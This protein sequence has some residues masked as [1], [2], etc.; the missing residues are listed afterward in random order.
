[1]KKALAILLTLTLVLLLVACAVEQPA[2][3]PD[4][5]AQVASPEPEPAQSTPEPSPDAPTAPEAPQEKIIIDQLG[6]EVVIPDTITSVATSHGPTTAMVVA[7]GGGDLIVG[8]GPKGSGRNIFNDV[9]PLAMS[10]PQIGQQANLNLEE[11]ARINPDLFIFPVRN[12][13]ILDDLETL[14]ILG[15]AIDPERFDSII[16]A[17]RIV[18][19]AI[20]NDEH[21]EEVISLVERNL[22]TIGER[23]AGVANAPTAIIT[24]RGSMTEVCVSGMLQHEILEIAGAQNMAGEIE[25]HAAVDVGLEQLLVWNPDYIFIAAFG[26]MQPEDFYSDEQ[27]ADLSAVINRRVYKIPS[28][29]DSWETP[30]PA[31]VLATMWIT[32]IIHPDLFTVEEFEAGMDEFYTLLYGRTFSREDLGF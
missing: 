1:M 32:H 30:Q 18:G 29:A 14:E 31:A 3:P 19:A 9:A 4:A 8:T 7:M 17:M 21:A 24:G 15:V 10:S 13:E 16:A 28:E 20:N 25:G 22:S 23:T 26:D 6:R 2:P 12:R 11:L 5:P 27:F